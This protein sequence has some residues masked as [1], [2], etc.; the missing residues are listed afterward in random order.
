MRIP[1]RT[2]KPGL[3]IVVTIAE[4]ASDVAPK[5]ILRLSIHRWQIFLVKYE[6]L[7]LLSTFTHL[8]AK[9]PKST[10]QISGGIW[11]VNETGLNWFFAVEDVEG[12]SDLGLGS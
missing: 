5:K 9:Y 3:H 12:N 1:C 11:A 8:P 6:Y 4:H 7:P 2:F 10:D